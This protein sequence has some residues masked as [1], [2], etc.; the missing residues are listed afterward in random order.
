MSEYSEGFSLSKLVGAPAGYVGYR[1]TAK[2]TDQV[3][4]R[5]YAV[6]L[7]D[8][9][10]KAHRDVQNILLQILEQGELHDATGRKIN[11]RN[12]IIVLTSNIGSTRFQG[13]RLGFAGEAG[14]TV[15]S[16]EDLRTDLETALRPELLNRLDHTL[17]FRPLE[18]SHLTEI[19]LQHFV[20]LE[21]RLKEQGVGLSVG[22]TLARHLAHRAYQNTGG[23]RALRH[24]IETELEPMVA[25]QLLQAQKPK[26]IRLSLK[27]GRIV[28]SSRS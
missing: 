13:A 5:P 20:A 11:F 28:I 4:A 9:I 18:E 19:A 7:F 26:T 25:D 1:E 3:K 23:A 17:L 8:E 27:D 24:A 14:D 6:V 12:T 10:E 22:K 16:R 15:P 21:T 2:L